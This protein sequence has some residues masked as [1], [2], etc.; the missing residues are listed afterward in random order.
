MK[1]TC[2]CCRQPHR[3]LWCLCCSI[4]SL[5]VCESERSLWHEIRSRFIFSSRI[6]PSVKTSTTCVSSFWLMGFESCLNSFWCS[7]ETDSCESVCIWYRQTFMINLSCWW[8]WHCCIIFFK[9]DSAVTWCSSTS[10]LSLMLWITVS[11]TQCWGYAAVHPWFRVCC[12][13]WWP[14]IC[15]CACWST[16]N[17]QSGLIESAVCCKDHLSFCCC[18]TSTLMISCDDSTHQIQLLSSW[19]TS[20]LMTESCWKKPAER[21]SEF[22]TVWR[23]DVRQWEWTW[24]SLNVIMCSERSMLSDCSEGRRRFQRW[25]NTCIWGSSWSL[26]KWTLIDICSIIW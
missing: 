23:H 17:D 21:C 15:S 12:D 7:T 1:C 14:V 4:S 19:F 20:M 26:L 8:M 3:P 9:L 11:W 5:F 16:E 22:L 18:S 10:V 24:M 2:E 6:Q 25:Q 13:C